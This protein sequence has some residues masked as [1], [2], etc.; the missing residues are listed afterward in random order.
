MLPYAKVLSLATTFARVASA[1]ATIYLPA[2]TY[3]GDGLTVPAN[4][5]LKGDGAETKITGSLTVTTSQGIK[6]ENLSLD[7]VTLNNARACTFEAVTFN[8]TTTFSGATY[9]NNFRGCTWNKLGTGLY[10]NELCNFNHLHGCRVFTREYAIRFVGAANG[11]T[12]SS[13][14][15]EG[16]QSGGV[17]EG[18]GVIYLKGNDHYLTANWYERGANNIWDPAT[19]VLDATTNRC[20]IVGGVR[21]YLFSVQDA[22]AGNTY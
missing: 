12:V 16:V 9:Y 3:N 20:R 17:G 10:V 21:G 6:V 18:A 15:F 14:S 22:G 13:T 8:G 7:S 4:C 5:V 19:I 2:G 11:W 1:P